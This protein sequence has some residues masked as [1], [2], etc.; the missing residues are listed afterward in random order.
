M[1]RPL[2][3]RT[4]L[5]TAPV[6]GVR[7][8]RVERFVPVYDAH[9][10]VEV[11]TRL[12]MGRYHETIGGRDP[13]VVT[14]RREHDAGQ[15]LHDLT[16]AAAGFMAD[17]ADNEYSFSG[18]GATYLRAALATTAADAALRGTAWNDFAIAVIPLSDPAV[19][20]GFAFALDIT[21][22][23]GSTTGRAPFPAAGLAAALD[24]RP[25]LIGIEF[26]TGV[27]QDDGN[28]T[29]GMLDLMGLCGR[30]SSVFEL[31]FDCSGAL[32]QLANPA[33][34]VPFQVQGV[35]ANGAADAPRWRG[36][37]LLLGLEGRPEYSRRQGRQVVADQW[38]RLGAQLIWRPASPPP[39]YDAVDSTDSPALV[40]TLQAPNAEPIFDAFMQDDVEAIA[41]SVHAALGGS[42][43]TRGGANREEEVPT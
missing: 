20:G 1:I 35:R 26:E 38:Q 4:P 11:L 22:L 6:R 37:E 7:A 23:P 21:S 9:E 3:Y 32:A 43:G 29:V 41:A 25:G 28:A 39:G 12:G 19:S 33:L 24:R 17:P 36:V 15:L 40:V 31:A 18:D 10:A 13:S 27:G 5:S 16:N 8:Y 2:G 34:T 42:T 30:L 14:R